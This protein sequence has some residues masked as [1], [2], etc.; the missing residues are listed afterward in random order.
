MKTGGLGGLFFSISNA[1]FVYLQ[2][3]A[4]PRLA[5]EVRAVAPQIEGKLVYLRTPDGRELPVRASGEIPS[6]RRR[7]GGAP[8]SPPAVDRRP[9]GP[10]LGRA[11]TRLLKHAIDH[12]HLPPT[13]LANPES[14]A[15]WHYFNVLSAT[16]AVGLH[17]VHRGR[18]GPRRTVGGA[19]AGD[20]ARGGAAGPPLHRHGRAARRALLHQPRRPRDRRQHRHRHR[21]RQLPAPRSGRRGGRG[22]RPLALDPRRDARAAGVLP[23]RAGRGGDFASG[24]RGAGRSSPTRAAPSASRRG[25]RRTTAR[26]RTTTTTGACGAA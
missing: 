16:D 26:S 1:R 5:G 8:R 2:L 15:E 22:G 21:R 20:H 19:A 23:R 11:R 18:R 12:F 7:G 10:R 3:L 13:G 14:W 17:L 9:G 24:V 25:A 6:A 4:A